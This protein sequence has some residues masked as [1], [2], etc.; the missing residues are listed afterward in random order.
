[1]EAKIRRI[2]NAMGLIFP[3][4]V[5]KAMNFHPEDIVEFGLNEEKQEI[6]IVRKMQSLRENLLLGIE[7]NKKKVST[8]SLDEENREGES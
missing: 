5:I 3:K 8:S 1:M 4:D 6:T 7:A 2:G